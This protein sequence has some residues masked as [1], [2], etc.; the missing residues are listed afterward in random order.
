MELQYYLNIL[1]RR[2]WLILL[3]ML[4]T[5]ALAF[6]FIHYKASSYQ[7]D[8]VV[9][10]GVVD[11][12]GIS[13]DK[14]NAFMQQLQVEMRFDNLIEFMSSRQCMNFLIFNLVHHDLE[15]MA[16][17]TTSFKKEIDLS[18]FNSEELGRLSDLLALQ[19]DDKNPTFENPEDELFFNKVAK[20]FKYDF[21][22]LK[23]EHIKI[24][25]IG[26]TDYV[27][28]AFLSDSPEF[29]YFGA[30][31]F[32]QSF[33][34]YFEKLR[35][36]EDEGTLSYLRETVAAKKLE[37]EN[38][39]NALRNYRSKG[40]I[41][42]L[43]SQKKATVSQIQRLEQ[44]RELELSTVLANKK[45]I[46][47]LER[48]IKKEGLGKEEVTIKTDDKAT[49]I[50]ANKAI[51]NLKKQI[52]T[53]ERQLIDSGGNKKEIASRLSLT[54]KALDKKLK[55]LAK[56]D[57]EE[58]FRATERE[59]NTISNNLIDRKVQS[60]ID[61][62]SA[63]EKLKLIEG[64]LQSL[65]NRIQS[66]VTNESFLIN[67]GREIEL[68]TEEYKKLAVELSKEELENLKGDNPLRIIE[69]AQVPEKPEPNKKLLIS[70]FSGVVG[71]GMSTFLIFLMTF[72]DKS[73]SSPNQ[74]KSYIDL[75]LI[76]S[77][78]EIDVKHLNMNALFN[79]QVAQP[80]EEKFREFV[81]NLRFNME[82]EDGN[83]IYL[84]T[85]PRQ[86][87]GKSFLI[88]NL[89]HSLV[90]RNRKVL[91]IDTNFKKSTLSHWSE[92]A[93]TKNGGVIEAL[94]SRKLIHLF[95]F[96][97]LKTPYENRHIDLLKNS[98]KTT[99]LLEGVA[100]SNFKTFLQ[101]IRP[102]Y[103]YILLE[104]AALNDYS[105]SKELLA[106]SDRV[107]A[108]FNAD[109][110]LQ[111]VDKNSIEFLQSLNGQFMGS[112]LNKIDLKSLN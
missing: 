60:K 28:I 47:E 96:A 38:K 1:W 75:P 25:R 34:E 20:A 23:K 49:R 62:T 26:K 99:S 56:L 86:N 35:Q 36:G 103:D 67:L 74:F 31:A 65:N 101:D 91:V 69:H 24:T 88:A 80:K 15:A 98:G 14:N 94:V 63:E 77:L 40:G 10:T 102:Q 93:A 18:S 50:L 85:S 89:A 59:D 81:S 108:V 61:L 107:I 83:K 43:E 4:L 7:S 51:V 106:F 104:G 44:E 16:N 9:A 27:K 46:V 92:N 8:S 17:G 68:S 37:L 2:K 41:V 72:L 29:S 48:L 13:S 78:N 45:T 11:Y 87:D 21:E 54:E 39:Q 19:I 3:S 84:V 5:A 70:A 111:S 76:G 100:D 52:A 79:G 12:T 82:R 64:N 97:Q 22:T 42:D 105:D 109:T 53:Y 6:L 95:T 71:A 112:V 55:D 30:S 110:T 90:V 57:D 32:T 33:I 66:Y 58:P 73:L